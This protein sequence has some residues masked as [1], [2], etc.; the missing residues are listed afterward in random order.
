MSQRFAEFQSGLPRSETAGDPV[1]PVESRRVGAWIDALPLANAPA[2]TSQLLD[3][4][5]RLNRQSVG[6]TDRLAVMELMRRPVLMMCEVLD[7][8]VIGASFP[9]P[10]AKVAMAGQLIALQQG[11]AVGYRLALREIAGSDGRISFLRGK[12]AATAAVRASLHL[13]EL[14]CRDYLIYASPAPGTW[15]DLHRLHA[16]AEAVGIAGKSIDDPLR[17]D[18]DSS[19]SLNYMSALLHALS[20]PYRMSQRDIVDAFGVARIL[21]RHARFDTGCT[22]SNTFMVAP[23]ED[24]GPGY[25]PEERIAADGAAPC[26]DLEPVLAWLHHELTGRAVDETFV[27]RTKGSA[28]INITPEVLSRMV[29]NWRPAPEREHQRLAA[30][31][32]L[33]TLVGLSALHHALAGGLDADA[34]ERS[35][36]GESKRIGEQSGATWSERYGEPQRPQ[37]HAARVLDQSLGGY[38]LEW[39]NVVGARLRVGEVVGLAPAGLADDETDWMVGLVRWMR[40]QPDGSVDAGVE[41]LSRQAR[42]AALSTYDVQQRKSAPLRAISMRPSKGDSDVREVLAPNRVDRDVVMYRLITAPNPYDPLDEAARDRFDSMEPIE[43]N[44]AYLHVRAAPRDP[45]P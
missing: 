41:L 4:L 23:G 17:R 8:Q 10:A 26:V 19:T 30:G 40:I 9:L 25:L 43:N 7:R 35:F 12:A 15:R 11:M 14:L 1:L 32:Q 27:L 31:H 29:S 42:A 22:G 37:R 39:D 20:N 33:D 18:M 3:G 2:A 16:F 36:G 5:S 6:G 24:Q 34:I 38:R 45:A 44:G 13:A 28:P 21:A